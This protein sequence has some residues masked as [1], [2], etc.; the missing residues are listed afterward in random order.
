MSRTNQ[1]ERGARWDGAAAWW[2]RN[3]DIVYA[4]FAIVCTVF[5]ATRFYGYM[6]VQTITDDDNGNL[7]SVTMTCFQ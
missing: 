2:R 7:K 5:A 1:D 6:L 3:D 4:V